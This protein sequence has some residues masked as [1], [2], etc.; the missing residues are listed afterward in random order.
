MAEDVLEAVDLGRGHGRPVGG[1]PVNRMAHWWG[2]MVRLFVERGARLD[3]RD[4]IYQSTPLGWAIYGERTAIA[5]YLR[6]QG[7]PAK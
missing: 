4:T 7:A 1:R 6:T 5:E 2:D 3:I